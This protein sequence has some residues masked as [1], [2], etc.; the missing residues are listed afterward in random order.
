MAVIRGQMDNLRGTRRNKY[1]TPAP[2]RSFFSRHLANLFNVGA[3]IDFAAP[4][5]TAAP[6]HTGWRRGD[7]NGRYLASLCRCYKLKEPIVGRALWRR[8][9]VD[10]LSGGR[11]WRGRKASYRDMRRTGS[12]L[13]K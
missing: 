6:R 5:N 9:V 1:M 7:A 11:R 10:G 3:K 13:C 2:R 12:V 4:D 8:H